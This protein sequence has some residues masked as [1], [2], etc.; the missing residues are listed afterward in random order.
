MNTWW[1]VAGL[2]RDC[3]FKSNPVWTHKCYLQPTLLHSWLLWGIVLQ[4]PI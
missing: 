4:V 3:W 2:G 1:L